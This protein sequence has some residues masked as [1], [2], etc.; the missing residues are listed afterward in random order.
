MRQIVGMAE[1]HDIGNES[2]SRSTLRAMKGSS[3]CHRKWVLQQGEP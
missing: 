2:G 1:A 3:V